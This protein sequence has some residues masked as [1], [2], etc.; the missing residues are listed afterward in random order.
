MVRAM[1]KAGEVVKVL[2]GSS[3]SSQVYLSSHPDGL[4]QIIGRE[5]DFRGRAVYK[6]WLREYDF[7][8]CFYKDDIAPVSQEEAVLWRLSRA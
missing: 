7:W 8:L 5:L 1:Y 3:L 6:A 2:P 4:V